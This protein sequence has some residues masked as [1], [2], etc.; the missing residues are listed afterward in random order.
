MDDFFIFTEA[1]S[2]GD[3]LQNCLNS[4]YNHHDDVIHVFGTE[5]DLNFLK[6]FDKVKPIIIQ[7]DSAIDRLYKFG[8]PGTA[9]IFSETILNFSKTDKIIH[10]DSDLIFKTNCLNQIKNKLNEEYD[11]VGPVRPYKHNLCNRDDVRHLPDV[12][13]TCFMG[14]NKK[15]LK[16]KNIDEL[17][18]QINGN[19]LWKNTNVLDFFD[20][21][22]LDILNNGGKSYFFDF[23]S[24]GGSNEFGNRNNKYDELNKEFECGDWYIHFA[25]IGSGC[26]IYKKGYENSDTSYGNWALKRYALYKKLIDK[27]QIENIK[28]DEN[29]YNLYKDL[30]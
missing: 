8:H 17:T 27:K 15:Y 10:F 24:T 29:L 21:V 2:C 25:G 4:F 14:F 23:N 12:I 28:I 11:L 6:N 26:R 19:V 22:S 16:T 1:Y 7:P 13:A 3:I 30:L 18:Y 20:Y 5:E 9:R